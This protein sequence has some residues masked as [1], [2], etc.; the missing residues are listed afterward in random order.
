MKPLLDQIFDKPIVVD[1]VLADLEA[2]DGTPG[3]D[4]AAA[5]TGQD[6]RGDGPAIKDAGRDGPEVA[7]GGWVVPT[8]EP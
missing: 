5:A 3:P 1:G 7:E 2:V 6:V 4:G 8:L